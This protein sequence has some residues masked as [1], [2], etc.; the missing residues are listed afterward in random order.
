MVDKRLKKLSKKR[1]KEGQK[2]EK[3]RKSRRREAFL[4]FCF[5]KRKGW[6]SVKEK[7]K[8]E[9]LLRWKGNRKKKGKGGSVTVCLISLF[10]CPLLVSS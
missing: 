1:G 8:K 7:Q 2:R 10:G 4:F 6:P 3:K 9:R 5:K